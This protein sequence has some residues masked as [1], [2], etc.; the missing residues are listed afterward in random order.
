MVAFFIISFSTASHSQAVPH[1]GAYVHRGGDMAV[2]ALHSF[3]AGGLFLNPGTIG[4]D[5]VPPQGNILFARGSVWTGAADGFYVDGYVG[6]TESRPFTY[7]IGDNDLYRPVAL[8]NADNAYAA[9]YGVDP[10]SAVTSRMWGGDFPILPIGGPFN[11]D[12]LTERVNRVSDQE[13]WDINGSAFTFIT[14]T[15]DS[16]SDIAGL[17]QNNIDQLAIV[18]WNGTAW[19]YIPSEVDEDALTIENSIPTYLDVSDIQTSGSITTSIPIAPNQYE[20]YSFGCVADKSKRIV[21]LD[22]YEDSKDNVICIEDLLELPDIDDFTVCS[23]PV[24]GNLTDTLGCIVYTPELD[25]TGLEIICIKVNNSDVID[26]IDLVINIWPI[27]DPPSAMNDSF[28]VDQAFDIKMRV[29]D[30]D[31]DIDGDEL[32]IE[33][34]IS[35]PEVGIAMIEGDRI[36]YSPEVGYLGF[37]TLVYVVCDTALCDTALVVI[38]VNDAGGLD[39]ECVVINTS[40]YLEGAY[41]YVTE[42]MK[43]DLNRLGY[44]PGQKPETYFGTKTQAGHPYD[45]SPWFYDGDEGK[46]FDEAILDDNFAGYDEDIVDYVLVTIRS[47][48]NAESELCRR[49]AW[50]HSDGELSFLSENDCCRLD[51][52]RSYYILIEHRNHLAVM[53]HQKLSVQDDTLSY[54]FRVQDGYI[55]VLGYSQKEIGQN[56]YVMYGGNGDQSIANSSAVDINV[57]DLSAWLIDDGLN[58]SYYIMDFDL[59]G[60][61]NVQDKGLFLSNSGV[62]S[63]V[64]L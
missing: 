21:S 46:L 38:E 63:D 39:N 16:D 59:N 31:F 62:F 57:H 47:D 45:I 27:N 5:R 58:S 52:N 28:L 60:D 61:V 13:Y 10:T 15:W 29:L 64:N 48:N 11:S 35:G 3:T 14:L 32:H 44:L 49:A 20:V 56:T 17:T 42:K 51:R 26:T 54:D 55:D 40:V 36:I 23:V 7:P 12:A 24:L 25:T 19:E 50:L 6:V 1:S 53:S 30:N 41:D 33:E 4:T 2:F 34:I 43:T 37:D 8:S 18:G 9:Y 22:I